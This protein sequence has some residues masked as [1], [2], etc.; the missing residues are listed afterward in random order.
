MPCYLKNKRAK[1]MTKEEKQQR[2]YWNCEGLYDTSWRLETFRKPRPSWDHEHCHVCMRC[3][4]EADYGAPDALQV[5][6]RY[7]FPPEPGE[8]SVRDDWLCPA[9][10]EELK[11]TFR[12][13]ISE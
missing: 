5:A 13:R 2:E 4:A 11:N 8:T 3:I 7:I 10:F 6:Y 12:W 9:C 1:A